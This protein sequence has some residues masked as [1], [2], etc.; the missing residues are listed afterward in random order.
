[1]SLKAGQMSAGSRLAYKAVE[2]V[3]ATLTGQIGEDYNLPRASC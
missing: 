2:V 3:V 1:M